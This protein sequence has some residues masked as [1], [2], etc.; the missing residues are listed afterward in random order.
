MRKIKSKS[1]IIGLI[2]VGCKTSGGKLDATIAEDSLLDL[3]NAHL[4]QVSSQGKISESA[5]QKVLAGKLLQSE[6]PGQEAV[7]SRS[8]W[9]LLNVFCSSAS[10]IEKSGCV[11][12]KSD[13]E[14]NTI[15]ES[16]S[17]SVFAMSKNQH[18]AAQ[19]WFADR[20]GVENIFL[21]NHRRPLDLH[22]KY[23]KTYMAMLE[24]QS[25]DAKAFELLPTSLKYDIFVE[26]PNLTFSASQMRLA[27]H[28]TEQYPAI[29]QEF[30]MNEGWA[31]A[32]LLHKEPSRDVYLQ[33]HDT[34]QALISRQDQKALLMSYYQNEIQH[35][36]Y[37][38]RLCDSK[39]EGFSCSN[40]NP[41]LF[42]KGV[43][44]SERAGGLVVEVT[45][46]VDFY[47]SPLVSATSYYFDPKEAKVKK[48]YFPEP[49]PVDHSSMWAGEFA[50]AGATHVIGVVAE[51]HLAS[52]PRGGVVKTYYAYELA[53]QKNELGWQLVEG[54]WYSSSAPSVVWQPQ[55][56]TMH[57]SGDN[58]AQAKT[59]MLGK[60]PNDWKFA[61]R[62]DAHR[63][64]P[65]G[66]ILNSLVGYDEKSATSVMLAP[67]L[68]S[69]GEYALYFSRESF[70]TS[71]KIA[72]KRKL[73]SQL[74]SLGI[75]NVIY[76]SNIELFDDAARVRV[77]I[78][79]S[80]KQEAIVDAFQKQ[81]MEILGWEMIQA[82]NLPAK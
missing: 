32:A 10:V 30:A 80:F 19:V 69:D 58:M 9:L 13:I 27:R 73:K 44:D 1:L 66:N 37:M 50:A 55:E 77:K 25:F 45:S 52:L 33:L 76:R 46:D 38:G 49:K 48:G 7:A 18:R 60:L 81:N 47:S 79:Q 65:L 14:Q 21:L 43:F 61:A 56:S 5:P 2:L 4:E 36:K 8:K 3:A 54:R 15:I 42:H 57:S 35:T 70:A 75:D 53:L 29:S 6:R 72:I 59:L 28:I 24:S 51:L 26:D 39:S 16:P 63:G 34:A 67:M 78:M 11:R 12:D 62:S 23:Y 64:V 68:G 20:Y 71:S 41:V 22:G 74:E 31:R 17:V 82:Q 40:M